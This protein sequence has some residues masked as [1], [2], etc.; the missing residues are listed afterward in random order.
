MIPDKM[1][2][3]FGYIKPHV[4][5]TARKQYNNERTPPVDRGEKIVKG[6]F[7]DQIREADYEKDI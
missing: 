1:N 4:K 7:I 5:H 3:L 2:G 6:I